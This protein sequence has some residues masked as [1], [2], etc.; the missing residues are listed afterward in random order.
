MTRNRIIL[1]MVG[2]ICV[3]LLSC[4]DKKPEGK[5]DRWISY[6]ETEK[7]IF[8]YD[9]ISVK[10]IS[11]KIIK[12]L[13]R[14]N[15]TKVGK[16]ETI[17][18]RKDSHLP[19]KGWDKLDSTM[20]FE[21]VDCMNNTTKVLTLI[22]SDDAGNILFEYDIPNPEIQRALPESGIESLLNKVCTK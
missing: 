11:P 2:V 3:F 16:D 15:L 5:T 21:E 17:Q 12:V 1:I 14:E 13:T 18:I 8:Y 4:S 19:I 10:K 20:L 9:R 6:W 22:Q 7:G